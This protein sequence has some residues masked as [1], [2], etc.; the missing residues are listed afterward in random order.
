MTFTKALCIG[1]AHINVTGVKIVISPPSPFLVTV[2]KINIDE[3]TLVVQL[4][5]KNKIIKLQK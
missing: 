3:N 1:K 5:W 4:R 2:S